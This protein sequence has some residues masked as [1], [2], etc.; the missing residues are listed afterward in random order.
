[1]IE[2]GGSKGRI[3]L[4]GPCKLT[5]WLKCVCGGIECAFKCQYLFTIVV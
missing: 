2:D 5:L 3:I 4:N 1:M